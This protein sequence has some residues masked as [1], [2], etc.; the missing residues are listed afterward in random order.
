MDVAFKI[1]EGGTI[2]ASPTETLKYSVAGLVQEATGQLTMK[3]QFE[4]A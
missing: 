2:S 3:L 4:G 1:E